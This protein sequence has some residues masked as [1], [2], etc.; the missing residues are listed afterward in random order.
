MLTKIKITED[1]VPEDLFWLCEL[2]GLDRFVKIVETA[3]GEFLYIPTVQK[4]KRNKLRATICEEYRK[5]KD[6]HALARASGYSAR[7]IRTILQEGGV[8]D[9]GKRN[10]K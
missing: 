6:V 10:R 4:L 2:V 8:G 1:D 9:Y 7:H 3:G 5:G